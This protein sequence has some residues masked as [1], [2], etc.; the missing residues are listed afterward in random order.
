M[1]SLFTEATLPFPISVGR[2][3]GGAA[4]RLSAAG[5]AGGKEVEEED[6][7]GGSLLPQPDL[8]AGEQYVSIDIEKWGLK[9]ADTYVDPFI[10][11]CVYGTARAPACVC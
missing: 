10:T 1:R 5:G 9:D 8:L 4:V 3:D 11:I 2:L 6:T 7:R